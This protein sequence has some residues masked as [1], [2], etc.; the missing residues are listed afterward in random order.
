M[1]NQLIEPLR[2]WTETK[3]LFTAVQSGTGT[4]L[5]QGV[6]GTPSLFLL[7]TLWQELDQKMLIVTSTASAAERLSADL[8]VLVGTERCLHFPA[9]D[10]LA[11]EEAYEKEVAGQ[12]LFVLNKLLTSAK[13]IVITSWPAL[14]RKVLPPQKLATFMT[15]VTIGEKV[16]WDNLLRKLVTVGYERVPKVEAPVN[17]VCAAILLIFTP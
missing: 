12:R 3:K 1:F 5:G 13:P 4:V 16:G 11:H 9:Y 2:A 8:A 15:R 6:R 17:L 7:A 10:L 14:V